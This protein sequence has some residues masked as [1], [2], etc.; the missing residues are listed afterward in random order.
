MNR[1]HLLLSALVAVTLCLNVWYWWPASPARAKDAG[2]RTERWTP[3]MLR[4][5]AAGDGEMS[6]AV[7]RDLFQP[8]LAPVKAAPPPVAAPA[9]PPPKTPEQ[10]AEEAARGELAQIKLV[11]IVFRGDKGEAF[12]VK[13]DQAYVVQRGGKVGERFTVDAITADGISLNDPATKVSGR[14]S[15]SGK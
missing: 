10:L 9:G 11:G 7:R 14:I 6:A 15:V 13:G 5:K 2:A 1:R 3:D 12:V 4:V 8:R